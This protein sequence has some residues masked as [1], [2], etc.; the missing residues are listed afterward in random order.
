MT[1]Q[2]GY[3]GKILRVDLSSGKINTVPTSDYADRFLGGRGFAAKIYWD[4]VPANVKAFDPENLMIFVTGPLAGFSGLSGS[5]WQ[6]CGKAPAMYPEEFSYCNLG[7]R[8]GWQLKCAGYDALV[9]AGKS[10]K[11]VYL[12]IQDD[13]VEIKD[14]SAL[15]GKSTVETREILKDELGSSFAVVACGPA[16]ENLVS[17]AI[18]LAD[19]DA[20]GSSGFGAVMGSKKLKAIAVSGRGK[21]TAAK[22]ERL[23]E[24]KKYIR[25]LLWKGPNYQRDIAKPEAHIEVVSGQRI[26]LDLCPGCAGFDGRIIVESRDGTKRGKSLCGS[27]L[28][29]LDKS[30]KYYGEQTEVTFY[31]NR[32]C[33]EYGIDALAIES[34]MKWLQRCRHTG[35]LTDENT[36]IPLTKIGSWEYMEA[37]VRKTSLRDGF[38]DVLAQGI[39]RAATSLGPKAEE[40][41]SDYV[42]KAGHLLSYC[43]R[44][45][46]VHA[47]LYAMEPRQAVNQLH[48]MGLVL[49]QW[50]NWA[51]NPE[52]SYLSSDV[53]RKIAA[54]FW[55]S[56]L[57]ADFSTYD[58]KA[59]AAACIQD[60]E[61][62]KE[63]LILCDFTWPVTH[64]MT[65]NHVGDPS[66]DSQMLA[67]VTGRDIDEKGLYHIGERV[68]NLQRAIHIR[69]GHKGRASDTLPEALFT[70]PLKGNEMNPK[71]QA[72]GKNGE[73][74]SR[75]GMVVNRAE[76]ERMKSEY[77]QLRGWDVASG[78]QTVKRLKELD[79]PEVADE[80]WRKGLAL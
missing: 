78:L 45:F 21:V 4:E 24:V 22:P 74:T 65:G 61:Y 5:R 53:F 27:S 3:A 77:Y 71:A 17:Y 52:Y 18:I 75:I 34:M 39:Q 41:V 69:E 23:S 32:L 66:I 44:T 33:D 10:E 2:Y 37:L 72:P 60:R 30:T 68:F 8:W 31:V 64:T 56:E 20:S 7:G 73:I 62:A 67:A 59:L 54:R 28:F 38:G 16:G 14:A 51:N 70:T 29:Y 9:V 57:A 13:L 26:K 42:S 80:L 6:V 12:F 15:W 63:C 11:P 19:N 40:L 48:E 76:F 55:G 50:V 36:G 58:G 35:I 46:P 25:Q 43:P 1:Q 49:F 47:L 79:L